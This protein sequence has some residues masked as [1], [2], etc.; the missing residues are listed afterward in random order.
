M[1]G[2]LLRPL[3]T[4]EAVLAQPGGARFTAL[5]ESELGCNGATLT[6]HLQALVAAGYL[7]KQGREGCYCPGPAS[8]RLLAR[9][10]EAQSTHRLLAA[11]VTDLAAQCELA[12]GYYQL[13]GQHLVLLERAVPPLG[14]QILQQGQSVSAPGVHAMGLAILAEL[15]DAEAVPLAAAWQLAHDDLCEHRRDLR[16][17]GVLSVTHRTGRLMIERTAAVVRDAAG[18]AVGAI[19]VVCRA[20][21]ASP[22]VDLAAAVTRAAGRAS[23]IVAALP[24]GSAERPA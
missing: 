2:T 1:S 5:L 14:V 21:D 11:L 6:R 20:G 4:L 10:A 16:R 8:T 3:Q 7:S 24:A 19:G 9:F 13:Q 15:D 12:A 18:A 23:R 22:A 17:S